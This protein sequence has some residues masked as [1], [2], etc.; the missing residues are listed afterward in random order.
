MGK[1]GPYANRK[2]YQLPDGTWAIDLANGRGRVLVDQADAAFLQ[3]FSWSLNRAAKGNVCYAAGRVNGKNVSMHR[4]LMG[5][6]DLDVNHRNHDGLDNRRAN[7]ELVTHQQNMRHARRHGQNEKMWLSGAPISYC[8]ICKQIA[9][10][11]MRV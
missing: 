2:A 11:E 8:R 7:L 5:F 1:C 6:P 9:P 4:L 10:R 3:Q